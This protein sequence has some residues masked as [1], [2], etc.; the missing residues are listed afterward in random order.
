MQSKLLDV[1]PP[2][3]LASHSGALTPYELLNINTLRL[4]SFR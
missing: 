2:V 3:D 4:A 1:L